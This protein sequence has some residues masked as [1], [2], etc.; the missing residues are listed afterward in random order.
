MDTFTQLFYY[1]ILINIESFFILTS[2]FILNSVE[3]SIQR[4]DTWKQDVSSQFNSLMNTDREAV[5]TKMTVFNQ[6]VN[7]A[8]GFHDKAASSKPRRDSELT[9][10]EKSNTGK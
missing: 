2:I 8:K 9:K 4:L 6:L 5:A 7:D 1:Y 3:N 10:G